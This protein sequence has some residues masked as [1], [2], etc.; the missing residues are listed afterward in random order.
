MSALGQFERPGNERFDAQ[1]QFKLVCPR[2]RQTFDEAL[3]RC[4]FG[5]SNQVPLNHFTSFWRFEKFG[6]GHLSTARF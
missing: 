1:N 4:S 2:A 3:G 5:L 6:Y